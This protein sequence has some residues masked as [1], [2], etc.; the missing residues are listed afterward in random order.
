MS[1]MSSMI[2]VSAVT[3]LL[4]IMMRATAQKRTAGMGVEDDG[5]SDSN[6][7]APARLVLQRCDLPLRQSQIG[8]AGPER[9][10]WNEWLPGSVYVEVTDSLVCLHFVT[11]GGYIRT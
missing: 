4:K 7:L 9:T 1:M 2:D 11:T 8:S 6:S 3:E 5:A 10:A